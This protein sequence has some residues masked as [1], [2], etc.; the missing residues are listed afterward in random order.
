MVHLNDHKNVDLKKH[1]KDVGAGDHA[2][3][4]TK[5]STFAKVKTFENFSLEEDEIKDLKAITFTRYITVELTF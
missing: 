2:N 3:T 4:G 1:N 5:E